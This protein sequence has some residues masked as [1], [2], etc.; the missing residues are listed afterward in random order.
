MFVGRGARQVMFLR[1][2]KRKSTNPKKLSP[3]HSFATSFITKVKS[4]I[5]YN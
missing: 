3:Q 5:K 4:K 1:I 2:K